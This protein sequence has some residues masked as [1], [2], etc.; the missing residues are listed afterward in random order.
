M[1]D[2]QADLPLTLHTRATPKQARARQRVREILSAAVEVLADHPPG[3]LSA[4]LVAARA[5]IPVSSIY[6]YFP[7]PDDLVDEL[8]LQAAAELKDAMEQAVDRPGSWRARLADVLQLIR[9]FLEE[10][11]YY[12]PLLVLIAARRGP[13][14]LSHDFNHDIASFL[15]ER[16]EMGKDG[17]HGGTPKTVAAIAVQMV[18]SF[19]ELM[20]L[21]DGTR[22]AAY[23][24]ESLRALE[25]YLALYLTDDTPE[26]DPA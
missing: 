25:A 24:T 17:F 18:L 8:Y 15:A 10:H 3:D 2:D 4:N 26:G 12:R 14:G 19:E 6:R 1:R 13:Q 11:P 5:G 23:M 7:T 21:Q 22:R 16:W 9:R 20:I